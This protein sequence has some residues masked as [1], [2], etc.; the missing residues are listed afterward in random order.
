VLGVIC[1]DSEPDKILANQMQRDQSFGA[2]DRFIFTIDTYL[3]GR[4]WYYFEVAD[5]DLRA[6]R[7]VKLGKGKDA[8]EVT[9]VLDAFNLLNR[10]NCTTYV[11]TLG[12]PL[13]GRPVAARDPRQLRLSLRMT[14]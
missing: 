6:S 3:D 8:R 13:F 10:V 5:F 14:F 2:N 4:S 11:G 1:V 7:D 9:V 12:S